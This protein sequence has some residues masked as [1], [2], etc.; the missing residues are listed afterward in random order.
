LI[1]GVEFKVGVEG[2]PSS[3]FIDP[4]GFAVGKIYKK[5]FG[6]LVCDKISF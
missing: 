6:P 4:N 3:P 5:L 1:T 2:D